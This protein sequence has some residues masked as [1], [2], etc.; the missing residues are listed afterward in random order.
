[1]SF[2]SQQDSAD[3][4]SILQRMTDLRGQL[5][6]KD[7]QTLAVHSGARLE[8]GANREASLIFKLLN[9]ELRLHLPEFGIQR[10]SSQPLAET[11]Q[12]L[13]LY[14]FTRADGAPVSGHWISFAELPDGRFYNPAFQ[15]YTGA[16]LGKAFGDDLPALDRA[17]SLLHGVERPLGD[18]AYA[19][20]VLPR[21]PL[22]L[23]CWSGEE[24]FPPTCQLLFDASAPHYLPTDGC[25]I[26]GSLLTRQLL[27]AA[28]D[29]K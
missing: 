29:L 28:R 4:K 16:K 26:T 5:G 1:V 12:L 15:G 13:T 19:F 21:L 7:P 9:E 17:A 20:D 18:R 3:P 22:L 11:H 27:K 14:Y 8:I 10:S 6:S 24:D 2:F 25:A 23:V